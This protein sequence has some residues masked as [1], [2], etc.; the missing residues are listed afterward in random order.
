MTGAAERVIKTT[1][2]A[3]EKPMNNRP[4]GNRTSVT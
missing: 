2:K 3:R 4:V 1:R